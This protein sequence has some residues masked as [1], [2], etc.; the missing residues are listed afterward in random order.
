MS[1]SENDREAS[2]GRGVVLGA[3]T[4][5]IGAALAAVV[6]SACCV[7]PLLVSV[8]GVSGAVAAAGLAPYRPYLLGLSAILLG[9]GFW[10]F[11]R[12]PLAAGTACPPVMGRWTRTVLWSA[13]ALTAFAVVVPYIVG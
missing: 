8:L 3:A 11:Y 1:T 5:G 6:A 13:T 10:L 4:G 9:V 12:P 2:Q 7:G